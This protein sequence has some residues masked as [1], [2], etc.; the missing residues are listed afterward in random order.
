MPFEQFKDDHAFEE[1]KGESEFNDDQ[2]L[3]LIQSHDLCTW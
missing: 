3:W 1:F 2:V